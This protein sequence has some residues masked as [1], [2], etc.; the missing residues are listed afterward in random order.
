MDYDYIELGDCLELLKNIPDKSI[1][2]IVTDPPYDFM[3]KHKSNNYTGAGAFG[4][5]GR[6]YHGQLENSNIIKGINK[7]V[8]SQMIR[9]MKKVNIYIFGVIK[10]NYFSIWNSLKNIIWNY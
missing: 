6:T 4:K 2:L 5:L 9:V 7:E 10:N 8:L 1:D 3:T